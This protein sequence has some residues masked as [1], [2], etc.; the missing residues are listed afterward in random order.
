MSR[1]ARLSL[2]TT[3]LTFVLAAVGGLVRATDSGLGCPGWPKCYGRWIPPADHHAIIEMTHRYLA[4]LVSVG[5][6]ATCVVAVL[7]HRKD[8]TAVGLGLALVPLIAAQAGLGAYVVGRELEAW[9]VVAHLGLGMAFAAALIAL[10]VHV[11]SPRPAP[12]ISVPPLLFLTPAAVYAQLLLGSWVTGRGAGLAF[13]DFP[14]HGGRL[15]PERLGVE[16][17]TLQFM[18]RMWAY[19]VVTLL[20]LTARTARRH[21]GTR[22]ITA[23]LAHVAAGLGAVQVV[24]GALNIWTRLHSA[25]VTAHLTVAT[26]IWGASWAALLTA[27]RHVG[28]EAPA[29]P[30]RREPQPEPVLEGARA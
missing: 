5:V 27:R 21:F 13:G 3:A 18:H 19:V 1:L 12:R 6:I 23:R 11:L 28:E 25:V 14:L 9:T 10:T 30:E 16:I 29:P 7:F 4:S 2:G 22:S 15:V 8:R 26:L 24:I 20:F 17:P